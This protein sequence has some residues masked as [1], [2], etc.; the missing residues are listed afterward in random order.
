[1]DEN[2]LNDMKA[3]K[4]Q[5]FEQI[6]KDY[7]RMTATYVKN[8]NG[9]E[10]DAKDIFQEAIMV[11]VKN[12]KKTDFKLTAK[13]STYLYSISRQLWLYK[14]RGKKNYPTL[15]ISE[16]KEP[17]IDLEDEELTRKQYKEQ[18]HV[19]IETILEQLKEDCK[20]L[21]KSYYYK[22]LSLGV[23]AKQMDYTSAFVKVKK[24]RCMNA[25]KK[26]IEQNPDYKNL[27]N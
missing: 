2:L 22:K 20:E 8:N 19:L 13:L 9:T 14:L 5:A 18:K 6:Y 3:G 21:I 1:M 12:F 16:G 15:D 11:L 25:F 23:I 17:F 24:N 27:Q 7:Y 4:S 26:K 10:D